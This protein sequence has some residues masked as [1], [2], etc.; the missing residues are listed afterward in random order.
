MRV[1]L[2]YD[3]YASLTSEKNTQIF[4]FLKGLKCVLENEQQLD[5]ERR[6]VF[7]ELK[8][9]LEHS[10]KTGIEYNIIKQKELGGDAKLKALELAGLYAKGDF[11]NMYT[12]L[13]FSRFEN[14]ETVKF[15]MRGRHYNEK[16]KHILDVCAAG[17]VDTQKYLERGMSIER[18]HYDLTYL[19]GDTLW[20]RN[21][22]KKEY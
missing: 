19:F 6:K 7:L 18:A 14:I 22:L 16:M 11:L 9:E 21:L 15:P 2:F 12:Y 1:D 5:E 20:F 17:K 4:S 8:K 13:F 10:I 3:A